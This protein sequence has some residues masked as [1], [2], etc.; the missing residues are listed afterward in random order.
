MEAQVFKFK[1]QALNT[2]QSTLIAGIINVTPDSFSDGG[3]WYSQDAAIKH[4]KELIEQGAHILDIGG[5][6]TRPGSSYVE[7]EEEINRV[8]PVI[9]ALKS[10][11][12]I[13]LSIDTW[14]AP[15]AKACID[16]GIDIVNDITGLMGDENM[17]K[18]IGESNVG[19]VLMFN[20][21]IARPDH[22]SAK[23]FP[24]FG[25]QAFSKAMLKDFKKLTIIDL[26]K[27]YLNESLNRAQLANI[28][29]DHIMLDPGIGF[30]LTKRENLI[31]LQ[32]IDCLHQM[33]F[34]IFLGVSRKR[35]VQNIVSATGLNDD[36]ET[37]IGF[38]NRDWASSYLTAYAA[39]HG[40]E[41]IR[42]HTVLEHKLAISMM[43]HIKFANNQQ[44]INFQSYKK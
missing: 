24:K 13:P 22:P 30:G 17:A 26:M 31:L 4:A 20:S 23:I 25:E 36:I 28:A 15:V 19:A 2:Q 10:T 33:G 40:I 16:A 5:E 12:N 44:D 7:I 6:S 8:V 32:Q 38:T 21:V 42:T 18:V 14:K 41:V 3:K 34:P 29:R 35:F 1:N 27:F 37:D 11:Y 9:Q 43:D 39:L